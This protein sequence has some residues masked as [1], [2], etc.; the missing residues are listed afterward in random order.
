MGRE[1]ERLA[2]ENGRLR[3][4]LE[5]MWK[6]RSV[7]SSAGAERENQARVELSKN[8]G[9]ALFCRC[10]IGGKGCRLPSDEQEKIANRSRLHDGNGDGEGSKAEEL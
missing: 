5:E 7:E 8:L 2:A 4:Q 9:R 3:R 1:A 6:V 10:K